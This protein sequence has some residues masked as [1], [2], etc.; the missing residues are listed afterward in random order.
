MVMM[1]APAAATSREATRV[2]RSGGDA[3]V[4]GL[5]CNTTQL[6]HG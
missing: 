4:V 6:F 1:T 2:P 3:F 5:Q